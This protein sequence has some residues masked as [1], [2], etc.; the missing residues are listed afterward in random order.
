MNCNACGGQLIWD[1]EN[2]EVVCNK[3]GLV[4]ERLSTLELVEY[5]N[6]K[7]SEKETPVG[8]LTEKPIVSREY[9]KF[10]KIYMKYR[11]ITRSKPWLEIDYS[12]ISDEY[13]LVKTLRSR[14]SINAVKNIEENGYWDLVKEGLNYISLVNPAFL[15]RS[16][17][18]KYAL[19]YII[20]AR[21]R[22]GVYPSR[23]IVKEVFNISDT[24]YRRLCIVANKLIHLEKQVEHAR[25]L[26][27]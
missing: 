17:R 27:S 9:R 7:T 26:R 10:I 4:Y 5:R 13:K 12:K 3:C 11:K 8:H 18:G 2:G 15:A 6:N 25:I 20:A 1:Y 21:L 19:A 22:T 14:A 16:E 23:D 24:S